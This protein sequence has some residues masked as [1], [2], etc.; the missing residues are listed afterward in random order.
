MQAEIDGRIG[1]FAA[2]T[3]SCSIWHIC[4]DSS[5][6]TSGCLRAGRKYVF[7]RNRDSRWEAERA[8]PRDVRASASR[9]PSRMPSPLRRAAVLAVLAPQP[10]AVGQRI[11]A[12]GNHCAP[13]SAVLNAS[14]S[15]PWHSARGC[16]P[17]GIRE[18]LQR[19]M[20][21]CC[22]L[23]FPCRSRMRLRHEQPQRK[24]AA[25]GCHPRRSARAPCHD[26][27]QPRTRS[28]FGCSGRVYRTRRPFVVA[29][30]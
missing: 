5:S 11:A 27:R 14:R 28:G 17:P 24:R 6:G 20:S 16:Y 18:P 1:H 22:S 9:W 10:G 2:V 25:W 13:Y 19:V 8:R 12:G 26:S 7:L 21:A 4:C 30:F 3:N 23:R 15:A 29:G